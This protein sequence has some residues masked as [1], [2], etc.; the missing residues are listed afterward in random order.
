M[1]NANKKNPLAF[2]LI[3]YMAVPHHNASNGNLFGLSPDARCGCDGP[4]AKGGGAKTAW[5]SENATVSASAKNPYPTV[6]SLTNAWF[7]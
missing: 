3:R 5:Y 1:H 7:S 2:S 4:T 6:F